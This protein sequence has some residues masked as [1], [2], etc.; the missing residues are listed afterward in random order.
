[1]TFKR[2]LSQTGAVLG[3]CVMLLST[4]AAQTGAM[5]CGSLENGYGPFDYRTQRSKLKVVEDFH[6]T[7]EVE[8]LARGKSGSLGGDLDYTLRASPNHHRALI[9]LM[10]LSKR[11][12]LPQPAQLPRPIECY[13]ERAVRFQRDDPIPRMIYARYLGAQ[14]RNEEAHQQLAAAASHADGNPLTHYNVGLIYVELK[15]H[16]HALEQAHQALALGL[17]TTA[18]QDQLKAAGHWREP[19]PVSATSPALPASA[20]SA[21]SS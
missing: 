7:P 21:P 8:I 16:E 2:I 12:G 15:D 13:F 5:A 19:A 4:A 18:L 1:M 6:F 11:T 14:K 17:T 3:A 20:A 9:A 10:R